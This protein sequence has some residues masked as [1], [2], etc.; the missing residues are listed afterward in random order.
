MRGAD[1]RHRKRP[2][3]LET[4]TMMK[5]ITDRNVVFLA[6][7]LI[8]ATLAGCADVHQNPAAST[9]ASDATASQAANAP[10]PTN[11]PF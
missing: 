4:E 6:M 2:T 9:V 3:H 11:V 10:S 7:A 5:A 1:F 8:A